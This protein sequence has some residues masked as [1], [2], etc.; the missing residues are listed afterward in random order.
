M[1]HLALQS[2][3]ELEFF[4]LMLENLLSLEPFKFGRENET[5]WAESIKG[6]LKINVSKPYDGRT[7]KEWDDSVPD[8]CNI[9]IIITKDGIELNEIMDLANRMVQQFKTSVYYHRTWIAP[10]K[11]I[12][13]DIT[14][15]YVYS[16]KKE[17][18]Y[19]IEKDL[20]GSKVKAELLQFAERLI[21]FYEKERKDSTTKFRI[22]M[23]KYNFETIP[24][25]SEYK[26][27]PTVTLFHGSGSLEF[28]SVIDYE[29]GVTDS[30]QEIGAIIEEPDLWIDLSKYPKDQAD[31]IDRWSWILRSKI[32]IVWLATIWQNIEGYN[33]GIV[34]KTLE[35]NSSSSFYFNDLSWDRLSEYQ[36]F[37]NKSQ[38]L[39]R[40]F[41][42]DLSIA[43]LWY[44][45]GTYQ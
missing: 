3:A 1:E 31:E 5:E 10:N 15:P 25:F 39:I 13:R 17:L 4:C 2:E 33:Y 44:Y 18:L 45:V 22:M 8:G 24:I 37:N 7:L 29:G 28:H 36:R 42:H 40:H 43:D 14:I 11:N 27:Y 20:S 19:E 30:D 12:I 6:D 16:I 38:R 21:D 35:N 41:S 23:E 9:G 34:T 32:V 26:E